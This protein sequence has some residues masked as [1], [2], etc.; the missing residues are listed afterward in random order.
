MAIKGAP[1]E[2]LP[3]TDCK[4][5]EQDR[6]RRPRMPLSSIENLSLGKENAGVRK[7]KLVVGKVE[8][9]VEQEEPFLKE[10]PQR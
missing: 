7:E 2:P 8:N 4:V 6:A 1:R 10:N 3:V 9:K 5:E